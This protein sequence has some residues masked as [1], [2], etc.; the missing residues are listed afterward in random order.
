VSEGNEAQD[1][2]D[3]PAAGV[4]RREVLKA[5]LGASLIGAGA[6]G[7]A[8]V[9][10]DEPSGRE[11]GGKAP[12]HRIIDVHNHP[13]WLSHNTTKALEDM[14]RAGIERAWLLSWEL[15]EHEMSP[16]YYQT[17]NPLGV[18]IPFADVVRACEAA[19][20]RFVAGYAPDPRHPHAQARLRSAVAIHG[21][22]VCGELKVR[23][24]YDDPDVV[25]LFHLCG[26]LGLPVIFHLDVTL[27]R[28]VPQRGRQFWYGG[29]IDAVERALRQCPQTQFLG[30]APGFWREI[31]GDA[32]QELETY[33]S[34][35]PI[36]PGGKIPR[37]LDRY[38]N[39][40]CDLSAGSGYT[41]LSR[42]LDFTRRFLLEY[43]DRVFFGRDEFGTK[44]YDLLVSL[45]L[46]DPVLAKILGGNALRL[47]PID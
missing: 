22:R 47:V 39:L 25:A 8:A 30:H 20:Q 19:P 37:L 17:L 15:P 9:L 24:P 4:G 36:V 29:D 13:Y 18:A 1:D 44:L 7:A 33:P 6:A 45:S 21:V 5:A 46:P 40:H 10:A 23:V 11:V 32:D 12:K 3:A 28:G 2:L 26:E 16:A 14:D 27:P 35:R 31:S 43:Q 34:G 42:D 41:A 38:P